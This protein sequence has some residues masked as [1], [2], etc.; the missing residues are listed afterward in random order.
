LII[1][2]PLYDDLTSKE[3][4][5]D[6]FGRRQK[7]EMRLIM[8]GKILDRD[9]SDLLSGGKAVAMMSE[10]SDCLQTLLINGARL[11]SQ[12]RYVGSRAQHE[13]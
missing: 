13:T 4:E 9:R 10:Q 11:R 7:T 2:G 12:R 1:A 8:V 5:L 3:S 6:F